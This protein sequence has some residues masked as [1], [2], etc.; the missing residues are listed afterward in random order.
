MGVVNHVLDSRES[1]FYAYNEQI[2]I[3]TIPW[4]KYIEIS[5]MSTKLWRCVPTPLFGVKGWKI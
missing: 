2:F 3:R 4:Q 5:Q 1:Q